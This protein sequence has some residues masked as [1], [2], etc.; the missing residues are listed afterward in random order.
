MI[1]KKHIFVIILALMGTAASIGMLMLLAPEINNIIHSWILWIVVL[2]T[3]ITATM[4]VVVLLVVDMLRVLMTREG[5]THGSRRGRDA[6]IPQR[7]PVQHA[8]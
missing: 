7:A 3:A 4:I 6:G 5:C 8:G 1:M 2:F